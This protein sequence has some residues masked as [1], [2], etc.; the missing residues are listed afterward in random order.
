MTPEPAPPLPSALALEAALSVHYDQAD[1]IY[2]HGRL[3]R[4]GSPPDYVWFD[5]SAQ[6]YCPAVDGRHRPAPAGLSRWGGDMT[7]LE[8]AVLLAYTAPMGVATGWFMRLGG[9]LLDRVAATLHVSRAVARVVVCLA[10]TI[11]W[12]LAAVLCAVLILRPRQTH[13]QDCRC[14]LDVAPRSGGRR[15]AAPLPRSTS[16]D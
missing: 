4:S 16:H 8:L 1:C 12:P 15:G 7:G 14:A 9:V 13:C 11:G 2:C 5:H 3:S 10:C 6:T